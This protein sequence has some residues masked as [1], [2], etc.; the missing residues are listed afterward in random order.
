M[1]ESPQVITLFKISVSLYLSDHAAVFYAAV[2]VL[3][4]LKNQIKGVDLAP[5]SR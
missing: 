3:M 4:M 1:T 2:P 5:R